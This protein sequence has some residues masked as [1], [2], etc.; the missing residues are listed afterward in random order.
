MKQYTQLSQEERENLFLLQKEG[1]S[2]RAIGRVINRSHTTLSREFK[3]NTYKAK[4]IGYLPDRANHLAKSRKAKHGRKI[5]RY[6]WLKEE[7]IRLMQE[8]RYSPEMVAGR[9]KQRKSDITISHETIYQFIYSVEGSEQQLYRLLMRSRP[10]RNQYYGRKTRSNYG[11]PG[12]VSISERP[13]LGPKEFGNFEADLTFF[14]GSKSINLSTMV[15]RKTGYLVA[16]LNTTKHS[17]NISLQVIKGLLKFPR[18]KRRSITFD[19]GK[20]FVG[21]QVIKQVTGTPTYFCNPGS[22]W[23]KPYAETAHALL[24]R[25]ISKKTDPK[26]LTQEIV[27]NAIIKLNNLPRKRHKFRTPAEMLVEEKI[28][29]GGALRA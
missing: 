10:K 18:R 16:S 19:N 7:I 21:H 9:L 27:N 24:H 13:V 5:D 4:A 2:F 14:S 23:Q 1:Q 6:P 3:R 17:D 28:Y 11:I 12:R 25:F 26:L 22:P 15:E 29:L 20:E 8:D